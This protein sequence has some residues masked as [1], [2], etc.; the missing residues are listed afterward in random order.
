MRVMLLVTDLES[1]GTP[2]RI[3]RL[4]CGLRA[5]GVDT[6]AG[7]LGP[8]G[9]VSAALDEAGVPTFACDARSARDVF[10][11]RR[12][13]A[14]VR[15][16]QPDL[17]HSTLTHAN[18]AARLVG[19][20]CGVPVVGATATIEVERRWHRLAELLTARLD[21]GHIVNSR[22]VGE[23]V[24]RSF[25]V[26]HARVSVVPPSIER[27]AAAGDRAAAR[28]ALDISAGEFVVLWAGRLD[29]VKRVELVVACA[30]LMCDKPARF[31]IAGDGPDRARLDEALRRGGG[32]VHW[33]GWRDD[34][35]RLMSAADAFLFPSL[36]EGM[37]N[38]VLQAMAVGLPVVGS[39]VPVMR[40]LSGDEQRLML[41][42]GDRPEAY[43][44]ALERLR[45]EPGL[46]KA[47][48]A[49]AAAWAETHLDPRETVAATLRV[50]RQALR[51]RPSD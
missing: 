25:R 31:L 32:A 40:E 14:Y 6:H 44:D 42:A 26:P 23:H 4:A 39:D 45:T 48:G 12:L 10:A 17:I 36:T 38:A 34:L 30:R 50:Y 8:P 41:V 1:G 35:D 11:L 5:A 33:L 28:A 46:G 27:V 47:L 49:R 37:P 43:V 13:H 15:R 2:L 3:A 22:A 16:I 9:P 19:L 7:C 24:R 21:R 20:V 18:V 51:G 29:P